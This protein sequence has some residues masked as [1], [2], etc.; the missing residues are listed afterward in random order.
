MRSDSRSVLC[1]R[2]VPSCCRGRVGR[3][4]ERPLARS[5]S[6]PPSGPLRAL[7]AVLDLDHRAGT[8][9]HELLRGILEPNAYGKTLRDPH[10]IQ[11]TLHIRNGTRNIDAILIHDTPTD[12]L[13]NSFNRDFSVYHRKHRGTVIQRY[14][15]E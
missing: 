1:A 8:E 7:V 5:L 4:R 9:T 10:P 2:H 11:G 3:W 15:V 13:H 14:G 6:L 12:A